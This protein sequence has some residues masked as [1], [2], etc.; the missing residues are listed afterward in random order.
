MLCFRRFPRA[1]KFLDQRRGGEYQVFPSK[2]FCL[3]V[4]KDFVGGGRGG[5]VSTLS[6]EKFLSDSAK[7]FLWETF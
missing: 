7:F 4:P 5:G 1:K 3:T 2:I 6:V